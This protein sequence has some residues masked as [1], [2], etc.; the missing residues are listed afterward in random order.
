MEATLTIDSRETLHDLFPD[1]G[2]A[3]HAMKIDDA[4][5]RALAEQH[6]LL[7]K[8]IYRIETDI[9]PA[10]DEHLEELKKQRLALLDEVSAMIAKWSKAAG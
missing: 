9:E 7:A 8:Q 2:E 1:D 10:S 3:L 4:H 5:F 6:N